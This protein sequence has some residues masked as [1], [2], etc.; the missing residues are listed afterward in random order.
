MHAGVLRVYVCVCVC[1]YMAL[2]VRVHTR[3]FPVTITLMTFS[4]MGCESRV[5]IWCLVGGRDC[6]T[7][8]QD[9][10]RDARAEPRHSISISTGNNNIDNCTE[11]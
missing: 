5:S 3:I 10:L 6:G 1:V 9:K 8:A 7:R 11:K 4:C 2:Y